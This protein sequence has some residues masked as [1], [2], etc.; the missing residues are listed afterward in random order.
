[1]LS[2][3]PHGCTHLIVTKPLESEVQFLLMQSFLIEFRSFYCQWN[4]LVHYLVLR[5]YW[6]LYE[7]R[8]PRLKLHLDSVLKLKLKMD[9]EN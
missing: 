3:A 9:E 2:Y 8:I 4:Y 6:Q 5:I 7:R 1:M